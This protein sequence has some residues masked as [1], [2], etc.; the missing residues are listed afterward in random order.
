MQNEIQINL[1]ATSLTLFVMLAA[2]VMAGYFALRRR[3]FL[4]V[5]SIGC[6]L[7]LF[8]PTAAMAEEICKPIRFADGD[9]FNFKRGGELV[10]VRLAGFD[11]P[12]V[13][14]PFSRRATDHLRML[15]LGGAHCDCYKSDRYGRS[16]CIVRTLSGANVAPLMLKAGFGCI[17]PRFEHEADPTD[18]AQARAALEDAQTRKVGIWSGVDTQCAAEFRKEKRS[19]Q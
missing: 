8:N 7:V 5:V 13:G 9:T 16:V 10:R 2:L 11:A 17:D 4:A 1:V 14:Q 18:R 6:F 3:V 12:E 19:V 15:T